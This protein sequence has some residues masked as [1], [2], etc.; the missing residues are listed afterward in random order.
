MNYPYCKCLHPQKIYNKYIGEEMIVPCGH[1]EACLSAKASRNTLRVQLESQQHQYARFITLTYSE[2]YIPRMLLFEND[3]EEYSACGHRYTL[4]DPDFGNILGH[5]DSYSDYQTLCNKAESYDMPFLR[6]YDLQKFFKRLRKYFQDAKKKYHIPYGSFRYYAVGEYGP[7]HF[8]PHYH[9]ILWTSCDEVAKELPQAV[10]ACWSFGRISTEIPRDDVSRYVASYVNG[11]CPLP[12]LL[13]LPQTRPFSVHSLHLGESFF[14]ATKE[15]VYSLP[16]HEVIGGSFFKSNSY[17]DVSMWRSLKA[18]YFPRCKEY[19]I[20]TSQQ[21]HEAYTIIAKLYERFP[22]YKEESIFALAERVLRNIREDIDLF[23]IVR[24]SFNVDLCDYIGTDFYI[25]VDNDAYEKALRS[26]YMILRTSFHFCSFCCDW[27][28][29]YFNTHRMLAK[30]EEFWKTDELNMLNNRYK[31][32][33]ESTEQL[34]ESEE[35]YEFMFVEK[36]GKR[37]EH[38]FENTLIYK[39]FRMERIRKY[40]NSMKHKQQNDANR[41]F[42]NY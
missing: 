19:D 21:R 41:I 18:H 26:L 15:K 9:I 30:I 38:D 25:T 14:Q 23:G 6:K 32:I 17:T 35:E 13:K 29:S 7:K 31:C 42:T 12:S 5:Y 36:Y 16:Y 10:S 39:K 22:E 27:N 11:S 34:F 40:N 37:I 20:L 3:D 8:R 1:C 24:D 28:L 4:V 2:D 33:E